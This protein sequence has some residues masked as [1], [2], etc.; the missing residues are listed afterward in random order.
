LYADLGDLDHAEELNAMSAKIGRRRADPGTQPN[1]ELNLAEIF[2]AKG[3]LGRAQDQY[4]SVYRYWK[5]PPSSLWMRFRYSIRMFAGMGGLALARGDPATARLHSAECLEL[6]T[7]T[8]SRKNLVKALRLACDI[9]RAEGDWDTAEGQLRTSLDL[10]VSLG[11]PVQH[12][13]TE[14]ALGQLLQD[15]GRTH[16]GQHAFQRAF[17]V[18]QRV[19]QTLR[20][21]RLQVAFEKNPDLRLVQD[22]LASI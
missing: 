5:N 6:A 13:K 3:D 4:D 22:L 21:E 8:G 1:A 12:W 2:R 7:R 9:A 14:I 17:G 19:R 15:A 11:N 18:M 16:E 10:A 20:E